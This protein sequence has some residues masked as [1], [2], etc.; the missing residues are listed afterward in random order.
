MLMKNVEAVINN[1]DK[2]NMLGYKKL[3]GHI[4]EVILVY[5]NITGKLPELYGF[6]ISNENKE[7]FAQ[8]VDNMRKGRTNM[9]AAQK[10]LHEKFGN[11]FWYYLHFK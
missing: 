1:I 4:E 7:R 3:P 9:K 10:T 2:F 11:T 5:S 6:E 8:Y